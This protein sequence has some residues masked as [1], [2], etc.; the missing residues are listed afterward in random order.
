MSSGKRKIEW[1]FK[2]NAQTISIIQ[3]IWNST[4]DYT[5]DFFYFLASSFAAHDFFNSSRFWF[6]PHSQQFI[7][8]FSVV[9]Y[10]SANIESVLLFVCRMSLA[11]N[12]LAYQA[13]TKIFK[14]T[15]GIGKCH[16]T[17]Q[18][19]IYIESGVFA[20]GFFPFLSSAFFFLFWL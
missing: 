14:F 9:F 8:V 6:S 4:I 15:D 11:E 1:I 17:A 20:I 18:S 5:C 16:R 12:G 2:Q 7:V 3:C 13:D 10:R 19:S